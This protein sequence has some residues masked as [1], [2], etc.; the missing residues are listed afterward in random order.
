MFFQQV[1]EGLG[2]VQRLGRYLGEIH[3]SSFVWP[4]LWCELGV[5]D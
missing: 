2:E 4:Q 3:N 5:M 1:L